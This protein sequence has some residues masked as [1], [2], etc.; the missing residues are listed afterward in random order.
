MLADYYDTSDRAT[1]LLGFGMHRQPIW[2]EAFVVGHGGGVG[3]V[4]MRV[5]A[6]RGEKLIYTCDKPSQL[7]GRS[8]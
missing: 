4:R 2:V 3:V 7:A 8:N 1:Y 6:S 5:V